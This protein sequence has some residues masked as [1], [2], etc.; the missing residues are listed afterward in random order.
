M[1][2]FGIESQK[3]Q[4]G[5]F[6]FLNSLDYGTLSPKIL[7]VNSM[8][9]VLLWIINNEFALGFMLILIYKNCEYTIGI[10]NCEYHWYQKLWFFDVIC[11]RKYY[12]FW[13]GFKL[14]LTL[15]TSF[16]LKAHHIDLGFVLCKK[17]TLWFSLF[18]ICRHFSLR[19]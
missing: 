11:R 10:K 12:V 15:Q 14:F 2:Y 9:M 8:H 5:Y 18:W 1:R 13:N 3:F 4:I 19:K 7:S 6:W 17:S 16:Y